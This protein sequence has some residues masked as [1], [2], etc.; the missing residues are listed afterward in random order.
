MLHGVNTLIRQQ[1]S[2][3][4]TTAASHLPLVL[5]YNLAAENFL[6]RDEKENKI[7]KGGRSS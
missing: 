4:L 7:N 5:L 3:E 1:K 2:S 6:L